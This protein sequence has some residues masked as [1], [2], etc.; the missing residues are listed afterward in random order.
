VPLAAL[1]AGEL[2]APGSLG[3]ASSASRGIIS[4]ASVWRPMSLVS[5]ID[6]AQ[7][8]LLATGLV[9]VLIVA[10]SWRRRSDLGAA[11]SAGG[12]LSVFGMASS[13]T[14]PWYLVWGVPALALSGDLAVLSVVVARGSLMAASYQLKGSSI[15]G[16]L[17]AVLSILAPMVLLGVFLRRVLVLRLTSFEG[18]HGS[19]GPSSGPAGP[20]GPLAIDDPVP[21]AD[22]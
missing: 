20:G 1:L 8:T 21:V 4:R 9:A 16:V 10:I 22:L 13:Y 19:V 15:E 18:R 6:G 11:V 5:G 7:I 17:G 14:L 2:V 3:N 12:S